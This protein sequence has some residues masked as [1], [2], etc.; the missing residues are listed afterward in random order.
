MIKAI[1][2]GDKNTKSYRTKDF[3]ASHGNT[4]FMSDEIWMEIQ[5][6]GDARLFKKVVSEAKK[7]PLFRNIGPGQ[8]FKTAK[9]KENNIYRQL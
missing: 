6:W 1:F 3:H 2:L 9:F 5:A 8:V 7:F 4:V